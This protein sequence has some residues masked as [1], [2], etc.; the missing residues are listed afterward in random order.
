[1]VGVLV[2]FALV[3]GLGFANGGF[4]PGATGIAALG[5][6]LLLLLRVVLSP[7]AFTRP[8]AAAMVAV[9]AMAALAAWTLLSA[10]WS[11]SASRAML[12]YQRTLLYAV[13]LLLFV[14]IG[15]SAGRVRG[16]TALLALGLAVVGIAALGPW[17]L[18]G[19]FGIDPSFGRDRLN[20]PTSY[21]NATGLIAAFGVV[22]MAH[23]SCSVR[24]HPALRCVAA[25]AVAPLVAALV[26]SVSR[27]AVAMAL[28][29]IVLWMIAGRARGMLTGGPV[30]AIAAGLGAWIALG[31][32]RLGE[33]P[34][35]Q[36]ALDDGRR[37]AIELVVVAVA[38][39]LVRLA[40]V[41]VDRRLAVARMPR[42]RPRVV[43]AGAVVLLLVIVGGGLAAGGVGQLRDGWHE[44]TAPV[45]IG[46]TGSPGDRL[47]KLGNNGRIEIW[48]VAWDAGRAHPLHGTGAGTF[49]LLWD[50][51]R[52]SYRNILDGHSVYAET[53]GELGV[54][55]A[56]VVITAILTMLGALWWR[57]LSA[58]DGARP[59]WA[60]LAAISTAWAIHA[61]IDWDWEMPAVTAW[62]FCAGGLALARDA[63]RARPGPAPGPV[64]R[65]IGIVAGVGC[66]VLALI[67]LA[68]VRSQGPLIAAQ[69]DLRAGDCAGTVD[70]ALAA[71]RAMGARPE[72]LELLAWCDVR[73]GR[74]ELALRAADGAVRRDPGNWELRYTQALVRAATG[75]DPR[76]AAR[77][78]LERNPLHPFAQ[79][80]VR[81]FTAA[82][83][84]RWREL[85]LGAQL[86]LAG[87]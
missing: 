52:P 66:V 40:L 48:D 13:L 73:L 39:G 45:G 58:A 83:R 11:H 80:A 82:H 7:A 68:A 1:V 47:T 75:Q 14:S 8:P 77:A 25:A 36:S 10:T 69:R 53:F 70:R 29:G 60:A 2:P 72:P 74:D 46:D 67:P 15:R 61:G 6:L 62:L 18:P 63:S 20:W 57:A 23:L 21:W 34:P 31:V 87:G 4:F 16:L 3:V 44:F 59:T 55:G 76:S 22:L 79:S 41:V 30:A 28:V 51:D 49:A 81:E 24:D 43:R 71:S 38:A 33:M 56:A 37:A 42:L 26:F 35:P 65:N 64:A 27:G 5:A 50:R 32:D 19:T 85:A 54:V 78:A 84:D 9:G 17:L 12:E 86:P